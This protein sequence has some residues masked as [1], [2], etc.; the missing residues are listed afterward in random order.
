[1]ARWRPRRTVKLHSHLREPQSVPGELRKQDS[2]QGLERDLEDR[3]TMLHRQCV[4]QS[5]QL[6]LGRLIHRLTHHDPGVQ[7]SA[8]AELELATQLI[9]VGARVAFLP[10]SRACTADLE[11]VLG[12]ERFFVEVTAMVGSAERRRFPLRG[13]VLNEEQGE[14]ADRG[15]ILNHRILARIHQKAKQL[16]DYCDPVVLTI[17]IPR[18]D[19]QSGRTGRREEIWMDLKALG[20]SVTV[21]LTRLRHLSAVLISLWDVHP[22]PAKSAARLA[23][24][25]LTE[26][27]R[28]QRTQ[29]RARLLIRN[30]AA[31]AILTERQEEAFR[32]IL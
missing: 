9:R 22:L 17:S 1:M 15:I 12:R 24:V 30:P 26:R 2:R 20:G 10:E 27:S 18:A 32:Q 6:R 14:E 25:D 5:S 13:I 23:N 29:P 28:H 31:S 8:L 16:A 19:L 21:L 11:C 7:E 4:D 3:W